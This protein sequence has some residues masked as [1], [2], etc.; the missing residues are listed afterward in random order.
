MG[1]TL[2]SDA[3]PFEGES[4]CLGGTYIYIY[5]YV[6]IYRERDRH[7]IGNINLGLT[8]G[9]DRPSLVWD[10]AQNPQLV[11]REEQD[12]ILV[13]IQETRVKDS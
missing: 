1:R 4:S 13:Q 3:R 6:Y 2:K 10:I 12:P 5:V 11:I 9:S 8:W 7:Y